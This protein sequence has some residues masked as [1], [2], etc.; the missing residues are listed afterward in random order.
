M[1]GMDERNQCLVVC[2]HLAWQRGSSGIRHDA[3][4]GKVS[5]QQNGQRGAK[6]TA[7][8]HTDVGTGLRRTTC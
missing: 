8:G 6:G 1:V 3:S 2:K 7:L 5:G 4:V